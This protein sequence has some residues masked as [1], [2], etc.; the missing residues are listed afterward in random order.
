MIGEC[1]TFLHLPFGL[2]AT[3]STRSP[4]IRGICSQIS[5]SENDKGATAVQTRVTRALL[6]AS[7]GYAARSRFAAATT[8]GW[9][10]PRRAT[11]ETHAA[12]SLWFPPR[13]SLVARLFA[14]IRRAFAARP[15]AEV[16]LVS[17][18]RLSRPVIQSRDSPATFLSHK[19]RKPRATRPAL[20]RRRFDT[21][22]RGYLSARAASVARGRAKNIACLSATV[23]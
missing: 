4:L 17:L 12:G 2:C 7:R 19:I 22:G 15:L 5:T 1:V 8:R 16:C 6:I 9:A 3:W 20:F 23:E 14:P 13:V 10:A 11:H 21:A 18:V